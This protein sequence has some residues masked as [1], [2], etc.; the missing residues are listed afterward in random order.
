MAQTQNTEHRR[1]SSEGTLPAARR[2][3]QPSVARVAAVGSW[4]SA[5]STSQALQNRT[6]NPRP[7]EQRGKRVRRGAAHSPAGEQAA[8]TSLLRV[9]PSLASARLGRL[10]AI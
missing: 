4:W 10:W 7:P 6:E 3:R 9:A 2:G 8:S 5:G 1:P